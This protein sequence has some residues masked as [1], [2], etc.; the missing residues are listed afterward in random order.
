MNFNPIA[1]S[2]EALEGLDLGLLS[3]KSDTAGLNYWARKVNF[4]KIN[5]NYRLEEV[6]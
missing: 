3:W 4:T 2:A 6:K 1:E 5:E